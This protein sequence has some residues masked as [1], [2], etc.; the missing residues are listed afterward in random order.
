[1]V[2]ERAE[3][4]RVEMQKH[5]DYNKAAL[6]L[7]EDAG[8]PKYP[9]TH[10]LVT[11]LMKRLEDADLER[12]AATDP[13]ARQAYERTLF[14]CDCMGDA[15]IVNRQKLEDP[16][17]NKH[18]RTK[19]KLP[20]DRPCSACSGGDPNMKYHDHCPPFRQVSEPMTKDPGTT[21]GQMVGN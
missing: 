18:D 8:N 17:P 1:M 15:E 13:I 2:N 14:D 21:Y 10:E 12:L 4:L 3:K 11:F 6:K 19:R 16:D 5:L 20:I 7:W 9:V